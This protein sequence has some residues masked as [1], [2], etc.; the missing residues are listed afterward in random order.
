MLANLPETLDEVK[1]WQW[2]ELAPYYQELEE[3]NLTAQNIDQWLK[4]WTALSDLSSGKFS[5]LNLAHTQNTADITVQ[6][7]LNELRQT[8]EPPVKQAEQRL[9]QK[10]LASGLQAAGM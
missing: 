6:N 1:E 3:Q 4:A 10:L 2:S 5:L 9:T 7:E 8:L